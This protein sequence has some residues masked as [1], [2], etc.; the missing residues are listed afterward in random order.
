MLRAA[1]LILM[2]GLAVSP[3]AAQQ[4]DPVAQALAQGD[5]FQSKRNFDKALEAYQKADKLSHHTSVPAYLNMAVIERRLGNLDS[6]LDEAKHALKAAGDNKSFTIQAH[7]LRASLLMQMTAKPT[8]KKLKEA[9]DDVHQALALDPDH[10]LSRYN[11]GLVLLRQERDDEGVA[12]LKKF[13]SLPGANPAALTEARKYI[14]APVRAREPLAPDF[15]FIT[16][17]HQNV[18]SA[19][20]RGKVVLLDFWGTWCPPCRESVPMLRDLNKKYTGK[21]FQ[22]VGISSDQDEDA[23]RTFIQK[24]RMNWLEY[25]DLSGNVLEAFNVESY[26]TYIVLDKD[27]VIRFRQAGLGNFTGGELEEVIN[28]ALKRAPDPALAAAAAAAAAPPAPASVPAS[29][30]GLAS[31]AASPPANTSSGPPEGL[32][33]WNVAGN[34]YENGELGMSFE[35]PKGWVAATPD[36]IR[37]LNQRSQAA[38]AQRSGA[39][40]TMRAP[41]TVFY[42]APRG[43]GDGLRMS[44]PSLRISVQPAGRGAFTLESFQDLTQRM[45]ASPGIKVV[46][47]PSE[48]L[49]NHHHFMRADFEHNSGLSRF[50]RGYILTQAME[51]FV[52]IE[53]IAGSQ[54][55]LQRIAAS[56]QSISFREDQE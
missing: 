6:A 1:N 34:V 26:P 40:V 44:L 7:L 8:D 18:T 43:L 46:S 16:L 24:Q 42:A 52:T 54:D 14:V 17:E 38:A 11:L 45:T 37:D 3:V 56:L 39:G 33:V 10:P 31:R 49:I 48:F 41:T 47:A 53:I 4:P 22:L 28:K 9:E 25:I 20:L 23:W 36:S 13:V 12:E 27:G 35:F 32:E 50:Y 19:G 21:S 51:Y 15:S 55:E 5:A 30:P 2:A 29:A